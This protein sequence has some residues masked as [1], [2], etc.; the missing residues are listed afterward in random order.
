MSKKSVLLMIA[1]DW[2][3][4]AGCYGHSFIQT[5]VTDSCASQG[6]LFTRAYCTSPSCA[7]SR[8]CLLTGL[9]SHTHGQYGHT[10]HLH[11]FRTL[12]GIPTLP[13]ILKNKGVRTGIVGKQH[14]K[15]AE[16]YPWD[17]NF[18]D[19]NPSETIQADPNWQAEKVEKFFSSLKK[20]EPFY[21][22]VG[23]PT[24]HRVGTGFGNEKTYK[25]IKDVVYDPKNVFVPD[26]LPDHPAVRADLADYYTAISR[27]D[28]TMGLILEKLK[29]SGRDKDTLVII[30][31]D[32]GMPFPAAK[33]SSYDSGH[34]CPLIIIDPD[35]SKKGVVNDAMINWTDILPTVLDYL[36]VKS[37]AKF[38]GRSILPILTE[39]N[40]Q[41]WDETTF[42]HSFHEV[43]NPYP[44]RVIKQRKYKYVLN[45]FPEITLPFP[46]DLFASPTWQAVEKNGMEFMG[47]RRTM[48]VLHQDEERLF[49][50]ESDP[51]EIK[52][53]IN[54]PS[55]ATLV[56][57]FRSQM[58]AWRKETG[59][60]FLNAS[61]QAHLKHWRPRQG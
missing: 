6:T 54:E 32:H 10:H 16:S 56:Q 38:H 30:M 47:K 31:S 27:H 11:T 12:E 46:T 44:Y 24:P 19:T 36:G 7:A 42:S 21:L 2:S 15:P 45:I 52:N 50:T 57:T 20:E 25:G 9:H 29:A 34:H 5:P 18:G 23:L 33:A 17:F 26:F 61:K 51:M 3:P 49:N 53:L 13:S 4:I 43:S 22:H 37:D 39:P 14:T 48:D 55:L 28:L 58:Q 40:P 35:A 1:D 60:V 41:G 59:D 8:A